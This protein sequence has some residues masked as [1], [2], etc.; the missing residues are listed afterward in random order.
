MIR[1]RHVRAI[2]I[3][4]TASAT[5]L[6]ASILTAPGVIASPS[7]TG[8]ATF[9]AKAAGQIAA[10]QKIKTSL[11]PAERKLDSRL[12]VTVLAHNNKSALTATP[13]VTTGIK[14]SKSGTIDVD[15]AA[16][17]ISADL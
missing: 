7:H 13:Q 1:T 11:T 8:K 5:L 12:A 2:S 10:L 17:K 14:I 6:V 4:A 16:S 15:I 9:P 3:S